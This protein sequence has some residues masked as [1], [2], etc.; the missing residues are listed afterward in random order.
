MTGNGSSRRIHRWLAIVFVATVVVTTVALAAGGPQWVSYLPLPPLALLLFSG[1]A[2]FVARYRTASGDDAA[3]GSAPRARWVHRWSGVVL[4]LTILAT[5]VALAPAD[6]IVW[7]SYLPLIPL[8]ALL[9]TGLY[10]FAVRY[11]ARRRAADALGSA[12]PETTTAR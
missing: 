8:A 11:R 6:P 3:A 10:L 9:V 5:F 4:V 1:I 2:V 12:R 7:V